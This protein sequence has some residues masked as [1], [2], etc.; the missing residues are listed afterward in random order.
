VWHYRFSKGLKLK[1]P[2]LS[3]RGTLKKGELS[4]YNKAH[5]VLYLSSYNLN[6]KTINAYL[7]EI[8]NFRPI[9]IEAYPSSIYSLA[10]LMQDYGVK[11]D[12][13]L[14]FTSSEPLYM[15][16]KNVIEKNFN[17]KIFDWYGNAERTIALQLGD[18]SRYYEPP[19]Y[20]IN[21]YE[22]NHVLTTGLINDSFPLIRYRVDDILKDVRKERFVSIGAITGRIDDV[23]LLK[24]GTRIGR[25]DHIFKSVNNIKSAQILQNND[26]SLRIFIDKEAG[27]SQEDEELITKNTM[28]YVGDTCEISYTYCSASK[29][30][31]VKS[32]KF[33]FVINR[34]LNGSQ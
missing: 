25:L 26:Y 1:A 11:I 12:I 5:N 22:E 31:R 23:V 14:V 16:Q 24:D 30:E 2:L 9:A 32:G 7:K 33:Q 10:L 13:P 4:R 27:Y 8:K 20:S 3:L 17:C 29:F 28:D 34:I 19:L 21:E 18:D 6:S 15:Y